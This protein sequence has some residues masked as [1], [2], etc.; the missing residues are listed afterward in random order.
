MK[1]KASLVAILLLTLPAFSAVAQIHISGSLH[2]SL[3]AWENAAQNQQWDYYQGLRL[4]VTPEKHAN[5]Y[6]QTNLRVAR[7]GDPSD[8][9]ERV[10]NTY[11]NWRSTNRRLEFRL[12][13]QFVYYGVINGTVDALQVAARP[14]KN[15]NL[16]FIAGTDAPLDRK[17][18]IQDWDSGNVFGGYLSYRISGDAKLDVSYFQRSRRDDIVWQQLGT[19]LTGKIKP[20]LYYQGQFD[21]N[22]GTSELQGLRSRLTYYRD[23]WSFSGEFNSQKPRVYEDSY[24]NIFE[25]EAF[26]QFRCGITYDAGNYQLGLQN[27]YTSYEEDNSDEVILTAG[28]RWGTVGLVYQ[29]GFAGDNTGLYGEIR[30]DIVRDLTVKIRSSHYSYERRSVQLSEDATSFS[31]GLQY[32]PTRPLLLQAEIQESINSFYDNDVRGLFKVN[33]SF[34]Q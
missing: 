23:K 26:N 5:F 22:L 3:Y 30:Y 29:N 11:L 13:R 12:G 27:L 2:S 6:V 14:G 16:K 24:F 34:N 25:L 20:N 28:T 17:F 18:E 7:R 1:S 32:R 8:W 19:A 9:E 21:Y 15:L 10:Y 33:Y 31:G 4:R